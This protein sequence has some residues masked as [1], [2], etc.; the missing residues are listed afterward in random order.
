MR[1]VIIAGKNDI[2]VG[3]LD[4]ILDTYAGQVRVV[5]IC[6]KTETGQ[7]SWQKSLRLEAQRRD[8]PEY[9]LED[10][11]TIA[12]SVFLSLEY[13]RLIKPEKFSTKE[14]YNVHFSLLPQYRGMYT[15]AIPILDGQE[16]SG[17]TLHRI[18]QGIDTGDIIAQRIIYLDE[19]E[20]CRS[21]YSKYISQALSLMKEYAETLIFH[22]SE[23]TSQ[24]Q[25]PKKASFYSVKSIDYKNLMIDLNQTSCSIDRQIRA[26]SFRE[27][28]M[29]EIYG[30]KV[31]G[32]M[33]T[34]HR[35]QNRPGKV[36]LESNI[37]F[38]L[39]TIDYDL[40][41]F[42]DRFE[43]LM[44]ACAEGNLAKVSEICCVREHVNEMDRYGKTPLDVAKENNQYEIVK[45][46]LCCGAGNSNC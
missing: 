30:R 42:F 10:I 43:E 39:A 46:L 5:V 2:A 33:Q 7:D 32:S 18:D 12:D 13:D 31:I 25:D 11:Y 41:V 29:P 24:A 17:V 15:S 3:M 6:N 1:T 37:G 8:V 4:Y 45:Y 26:F 34:T 14:L 20:T 44:Q 16:Y 19:K 36:I 35:S 40:V 21:L 9:Q 28:Q 38:I 27:Y 23:V 22:P